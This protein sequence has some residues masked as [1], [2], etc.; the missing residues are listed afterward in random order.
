MSKKITL[1][2]TL[3]TVLQAY[4]QENLAPKT[5]DFF[6]E[7]TTIKAAKQRYL[8][9]LA[10]QD[11]IQVSDNKTTHLI[12][13]EKVTYLDIGSPYFVADTIA[14]M[15][16]LKHIGEEPEDPDKSKASNLTVITESGTYYSLAM[17]Y[18]RNPE[19]LTYKMKKLINLTNC[20]ML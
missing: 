1:L 19:I 4:S 2:L 16:K 20:V 7:A 12:F 13:D 8:K 10:H 15:I 3:L 5:E 9:A 6:G 11:Y 17:T 14:S 18:L